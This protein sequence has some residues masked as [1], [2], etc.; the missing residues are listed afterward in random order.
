MSS[1]DSSPED[2]DGSVSDSSFDFAEAAQTLTE[3]QHE[4]KEIKD[5][6]GTIEE[7]EELASRLE[8]MT[9]HISAA[10]EDLQSTAK[11]LATACR[12]LDE[13]SASS[14]ETVE[15]LASD[16]QQLDQKLDLLRRE[17]L[18]ES[19]PDRSAGQS[20]P[21]SS[22]SSVWVRWDMAGVLVL[23]LVVIGL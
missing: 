10:G 16:V 21:H 4:L 2:L 11:A 12:R 7:A 3:L 15:G 22:A 5:A 18:S 1:S 14:S 17:L 8:T 19:K 6:N 20:E 13:Q 9:G 23:L